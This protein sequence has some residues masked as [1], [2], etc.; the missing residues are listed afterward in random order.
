MNVEVRVA[1]GELIM[2]DG[3]ILPDGSTRASDEK[4]GEPS[5]KHTVVERV[6]RLLQLLLFNECT[7]L[8]IFEQLASYS[9]IE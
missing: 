9:T 2:G 1:E 6:F 3:K 8:E 7:R 4:D 5:M